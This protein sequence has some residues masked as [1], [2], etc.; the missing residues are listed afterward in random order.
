MEN[1]LFFVGGT[2]ARV[3]RAFLHS[4][5]AGAI[6]TDQVKVVLVDADSKSAAGKECLEL[7]KVYKKYRELI[8]ENIAQSVNPFPAFYCEVDMQE[9]AVISPVQPDITHLEQV[10][11]GDK[12]TIRALKWFY[13]KEEREQSIEKGFYARPNIGCVFFQ[14]FSS[15]VLQKTLTE[16]KQCLHRNKGQVRV[17]LIGSVFGG[18]GAAGVPSL[19]KMIRKECSAD[20]NNL[21]CSAVL[22]TPYFSM[23]SKGA[24]DSSIKINQNEFFYNT[25]E[26]LRYYQSLL[27]N[28][29]E[30]IYMVGKRNLDLVNLNYA[31]GGEKQK[32]KPHIVELYGAMAIQKILAAQNRGLWGYFA[33]DENVDWQSMDNEFRVLTDMLRV[34]MVLESEIYPYLEQVENNV[35]SIWQ[36]RY[37]WYTIYDMA[38]SSNRKKMADIRIYSQQFLEWMYYIQFKYENGRLCRN[39]AVRLCGPTIDHFSPEPPNDAD[40]SAPSERR[41]R[42]RFNDLVDLSSNIEYVLNKAALLLSYL[43]VAPPALATLGCAGLLLRLIGLAGEKK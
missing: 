15:A 26:A 6:N 32:N 16:I 43:G 3:Y 30:S 4:C 33:G 8:R 12:N 20:L 18:T 22:V 27:F 23:E 34:Q 2:G 5:A 10:A 14:D 7:Y 39:L 1:Y 36:R 38:S 29:F 24:E 25:R 28:D 31:D 37:Q 17:V 19:L 21:H 11:K 35:P 9:E 40:R 13:T 42:D 41:L